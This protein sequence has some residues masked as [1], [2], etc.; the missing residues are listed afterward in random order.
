MSQENV[1]TP[2]RLGASERTELSFS[3]YLALL[4]RYRK[5]VVGIPA[6]VTLIALAGSLLLP[7]VYKAST[8]LLPPQQAQ[9]GAAALLSQL[10]GVASA[11]AGVAGIKSPNDLYVGMLKSRTIADGLIAKFDLK[12]AYET[13]SQEKARRTLEENTTIAVGKDGLITIEVE[14]E[15]KSRVAPLANGYADELLRLTR[16]LA[17]T[18]ASQRRLFFE[19]QLKQAKDNL[20]TAEVSL[21]RMIDKGGVISVD[22]ET[23]AVVETTGRIRAQISAK[24]SQLSAMR[25]FVT[26]ANPEYRRVQEEL[27]G[28]RA[29]QERL[30][31]GRATENGP[32]QSGGLES[33]KT[34]RDIK[35]YQMLYELLA[36]QYEIARLDE[37]KD[38]AIIQVLDIAVDPERKFKP[39]RALLVLLSFGAS[40]FA[41]ISW[42]FLAAPALRK[43]LALEKQPVLGNPRL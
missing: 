1:I 26:E 4:K 42:I 22:S 13:S 38:A 14:D 31:N 28:L 27:R 33:I 36:K 40:L 16:V 35:Y 15:Q 25:A 30:E 5:F 32:G 3:E 41:V 17:L 10:G 34:L 9:S 39:R 43:K 21:K 12:K 20:A 18:E 19:N 2:D 11:A 8:K 24:E 23:R 29:E 37:A 7:N 6:V